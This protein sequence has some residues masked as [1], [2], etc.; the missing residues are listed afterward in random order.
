[1]VSGA[2]PFDCPTGSCDRFLSTYVFDLLS[3][4][5]I[6]AVLS[7]AHRILDEGGL[8]CAV[9][10]THGKHRSTRWVSQAWSRI[11]RLRPSL[12]GGCRPLQL[13]ELLDS[14]AFALLHHQVVSRFGLSSEIL[15]ARRISAPKPQ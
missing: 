14:S 15:V 4:S 7:E 12:V 5:D 8:L 1:M 2:L 10:L 9:G 6:R 11:H 13:R 3:V